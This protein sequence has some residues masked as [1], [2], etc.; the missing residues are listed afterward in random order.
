MNDVLVIGAGAGGGAAAY[1]LCR[2]GLTV[3]LLDAGPTYDPAIDYRLDEPDWESPFPAKVPSEIFYTMAQLQELSSEHDDLRSWNHITGRWNPGPRRLSSGY[4]H[5]RGVG[6][7]TLHY[8]GEAHRLHPRALRVASLTGSGTDWPIDY[9][10]LEPFYAEAERIVGVAG[11]AEPSRPRS[12]PYPQPPHPPGYASQALRRGFDRLGLSTSPNSLAILS[13]ARGTRPP[14]NGCNGCLRGCPIGDKGSADVT[15]IRQAL[16]TGRCTIRPD[17]EALLLETGTDDRIT[18]LVVAEGGVRRRLTAP[19][20]VLAAGAVQT[21]RLLLNSAGPAAPEGV[22]NESGEVGRNFMETL[23]WTSSALHPDNLGSHRGR[24]VDM[25]TWDLNAPDAVPGHAGGFRFGPAQ[26]ESDLVGPIA[27]ATRVVAGWGADH[28]RRM[29][30][31]F[32]RVL[33]VAGLCESFP[34]PGSRVDLAEELDAHGLPKPRIHSHLDDAAIE[35]IR[36]MARTC[37]SI[38]EGAGAGAIF[39]ELG[40][41]DLF[42]STHVFGTCRMGADPAASVVDPWCRSHRWRNLSILDA[43]VFPSS[44]G[45][46]SPALTIQALALRAARRIAAR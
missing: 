3:T 20:I 8:T 2:A 46:E 29:R 1:A 10:A 43:S 19:Y 36:F 17:C 34:H 32:G 18:G 4:H 15:F 25:I 33:S 45:G 31:S 40:T 5:V 44:G 35:R 21:P 28:K 30:E 39:E 6:G 24:P 42:S 12:A 13:E 22:A 41:Y 7:S 9:E 14:C 11:I 26:A 23:V 37:R 38:L 16:A 27:Y